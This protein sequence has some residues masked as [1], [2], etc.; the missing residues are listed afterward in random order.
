MG[1]N[2]YLKIDRYK[3]SGGRT[4]QET[5]LQF[6][7]KNGWNHNYKIPKVRGKCKKEDKICIGDKLVL[8]GKVVCD[9]RNF[10]VWNLLP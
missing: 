3:E 8:G 4:K 5:R 2:L 7:Q 6:N 10:R 1:G 9:Q